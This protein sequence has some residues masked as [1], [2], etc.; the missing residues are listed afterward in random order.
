MFCLY[1]SNKLSRPSFEFSLKVK[2]M[3]LN[4]GPRLPFK[5]FYFNIFF[6]P[7]FKS[8]RNW[9]EVVKMH[10]SLFINFKMPCNS[11]CYWSFLS[12]RKCTFLNAQI[13][14]SYFPKVSS[15]CLTRSCMFSLRPLKFSFFEKLR[16]QKCAQSSTWFGRLLS[17]C[18]NPISIYSWSIG[19]ILEHEF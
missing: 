14:Y 9:F 11:R 4:P 1:T 3:G 2:V 8:P 18:P 7:D 19:H 15:I 12:F 17:K 16:S 13:S 6:I 5:I 10:L